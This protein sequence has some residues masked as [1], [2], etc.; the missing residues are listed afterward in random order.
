MIGIALVSLALFWPTLWSFTVTWGRYD[1]AHGLLAPFLVAWLV[2]SDR[3]S[4]RNP[5]GGDPSLLIPM[6]AL[7]F[8]WLAST[9][10]HIMLFSQAAFV[11][12]VV[13][14]ALFVFGRRSA[15][16]VIVSAAVVLLSMPL[17]DALLS[18]LRR[19][20]TLM[21]GAMVALVR[22]PAQI[23][24]DMIHLPSG[25]FEIADGCA[26]LNYLLSALVIGLVYAQ[27]LVRGR[28]ARV[29]TV[30]LAAAV[31]L[32]GNWL[33]VAVIVV[34]GHLSEM[35]AWLIANHVEFGWVVF[36]AA[37]M[38]FFTFSPRLERWA[39][40][41]TQGT[42]WGR[43]SP[44]EAAPEPR[45]AEPE[46]EPWHQAYRSGAASA[47]ALIGPVLFF[48]LAAFPRGDIDTPGL[49]SVGGGP[50]WSAAEPGAVEGG[51]QWHPEYQGA[52]QHESLVFTNGTSQVR[53][54]RFVYLEQ[55]QNAK[56]IGWPNQIVYVTKVIDERVVGPVDPGGRRRVRQAVVRTPEGVVM[57]WY[58]F[59]VGGV[60]TFM[61]MHAKVL[62]I[63]AFLTRHQVSEMIAFSA[64]CGPEDCASAFNALTDFMGTPL[65]ADTAPSPDT[66]A[67]PAASRA[68]AASEDGALTV[69]VTSPEAPAPGPEDVQPE[70]GVGDGVRQ[71]D[72]P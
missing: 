7:S 27:V 1:Y 32:F 19:V 54:D 36:A 44:D 60:S 25:S 55:K 38:L 6:V 48:V 69:P 72:H 57:T 59:R 29:L 10:M 13:G 40:R 30:A 15:R 50:G 14:W 31:A 11:L 49:R 51:L 24:G 46:T 34:V 8:F 37:L 66:A 3:D 12:M 39:N 5:R 22:V 67:A 64:P 9:I 58:W 71:D 18:P 2:W 45:A 21:S 20:T 62:E 68:T 52:Q 61:P 26:G 33:R 63:P 47:A 42:S 17:W 4:F 41:K 35:Q 56:L 65:A 70:Q 53:G 16:T 23:D 28:L 43:Q